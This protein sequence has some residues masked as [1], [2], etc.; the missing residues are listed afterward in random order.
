VTCQTRGV[1]SA[2]RLLAELDDDQRAAATA[3]HGPVAIIA[4]AGSGKTRVITHRI[5]Y[6]IATGDYDAST[7]VAVTFTTKAAGEMT[8]RLRTLQVPS[9][10]VRTFHSAALRQ[11]RYY[12]PAVAGGQLPQLV[13]S[14]SALVGSAAATMGLPNAT[15]A[16][17]DF[18]A[19][20]EWAKVHCL[21]PSGYVAAAQ[22]AGRPMPADLKPAVMADLFAAYEQRKDTVGAMDFEDVLLLIAALLEREPRVT[23]HLR[24]A[25]RHITV[26]EYQDISPLQQ[27]VLDGWLGDNQ[28]ICV[29]G[30]PAQTIYGFAGATS[31]HLTEFAQRYPQAEVVRLARTYRCS[32]QIV[33]VANR[34]LVGAGASLQLRSQ[35]PPGAAVQVTAYPDASAEADA[36]A[37][38]IEQLISTGMPAAEIAVLVRINAMTEPFEDA[39]SRRGVPYHVSGT[40]GF[41]AR[42]E[43][44][45]ALTLIRGAAV[46]EGPDIDVAETVSALLVGSGWSPQP[47][48]GTG[49]VRAQWESLAA[50]LDNAKRWAAENPAGSLADYGAE[51]AD[52]AERQDAPDG[53]GVTV[54]SL[55][56]AKGAEWR[57]VFLAGINE[58]VLPHSSAQQS[59]D[60]AE[61]QRL[62]YVGITR[63][64]D[65]LAVSYH[66]ASA[67]GRPRRASRFLGDLD[68]ASPS[69]PARKV[70]RTSRRSPTSCRQCGKS[71][72]TGPEAALGR[73]AGC[74]PEV[75][76]ALLDRLRQWRQDEVA[77]LSA[78]RE[79]ST[80]AYLVATD[81]TLQAIAE[82]QPTDAAEL[83]AIP[84]IG[85][86]KIDS[87]G[88]Q[89]VAIVREHL[90]G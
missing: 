83:S 11:L 56:S 21:T 12:W 42:P 1:L 8:R 18:A 35:R 78:T 44:R 81:A 22:A 69:A 75:D 64:A 63:A 45:K 36:V 38:A 53:A 79:G 84:G 43:V 57:A 55:H 85:P 61:E 25:L 40:T 30:D 50:L 5:A 17:R 80:P 58:G 39:F 59:G 70:R 15:A 51:L 28:N 10:R 60:V 29:V 54:A 77:A 48:L 37:A 33:D 20:I 87:Y 34:V 31:S 68:H 9:V 88:E 52:R 46:A 66:Q 4:G 24:P 73:C 27:R 7:S 76:L 6:G 90:N 62:F 32:P 67:N 49:S 23:H 13:S 26:D 47:P 19:E 74:A 65:F 82:Q 2:D 14:K 41:F 71:L 72:V 3:L 16:V 86:R 89:I